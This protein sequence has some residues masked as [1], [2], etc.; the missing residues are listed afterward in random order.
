MK[1]LLSVVFCSLL[2]FY[3]DAQSKTSSNPK[4]ATL[5]QILKGRWQAEGDKSVVL[6]FDGK[7]YTELYGK[8]T[9]DNMEY[10]FSSSCRLLNQVKDTCDLLDKNKPLNILLHRGG[11]VQSCYELLAL[12]KKTLSW[13]YTANGKTFVFRRM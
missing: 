10:I 6:I 7:V 8:D 12:T 4:T 11:E 1:R 2:V 5:F 13:M 3:V 9:T